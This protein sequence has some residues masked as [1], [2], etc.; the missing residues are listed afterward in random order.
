MKKTTHCLAPDQRLSN[1]LRILVAEDHPSHQYLIRA[2]L[3][4]SGH[5]VI[6]TGDGKQA[7]RMAAVTPSLDVILMD[8]QMPEMDG[9]EATRAIRALPGRVGQLPIIGLSADRC[10]EAQ[11]RALTAGM[12]TLLGKPLDMQELL[13]ALAV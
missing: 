2:V 11:Q 5:R 1:S 9:L 12:N 10:G 8:I 6:M 3:E 4:K 13:S 7:M